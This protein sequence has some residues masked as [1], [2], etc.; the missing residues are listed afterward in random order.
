MLTTLVLLIFTILNFDS[1]QNV[2]VRRLYYVQ[3]KSKME[4]NQKVVSEEDAREAFKSRQP[5]ERVPFIQK[6][7]SYFA[8]IKLILCKKRHKPTHE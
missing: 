6:F 7:K 8:K 5:I 2:L 4:I 1:L 3:P